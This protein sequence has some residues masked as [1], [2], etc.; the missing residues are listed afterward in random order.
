MPRGILL[1]LI[2]IWDA[3]DGFLPS[4][5]LERLKRRERQV[6]VVGEI[7]DDIIAAIEQAEYLKPVR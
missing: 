3:I 5:D 2:D 1:R 4:H 6:H 7:P